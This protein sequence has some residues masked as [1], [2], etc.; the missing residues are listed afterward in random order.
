MKEFLIFFRQ[1]SV[2]LHH[3]LFEYK[4]IYIDLWS[5]NH[6]LS[7]MI[8]L[9]SLTAL[10]WKNRWR[11]LFFFLSAFE[12]VEATL[13]IALLKL[14]IPE[15]IPDVFMDVFLGMLGGYLIYLL[16]EKIPGILLYQSRIVMLISA[17]TISFLWTGFYGYQ[18][19][20][21]AMNSPGINVISFL[22][23]ALGGLAILLLHRAFK[24]TIRNRFIALTAFYLTYLSGLFFGKWISYYL[25]NIK[26]ISREASGFLFGFLPYNN[27]LLLFYLMSPVF[28][29]LLNR[30]LF[31]IF[32][33]QTIKSQYASQ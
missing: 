3:N 15:K 16:F 27:A 12:L 19:N 25:L 8:V 11:W 24:K 17:L 33:Q 5:I 21:N 2:W 4:L 6:F 23:W 1:H 22:S 13:F 28:F 20:I 10:G 26:E 31:H 32:N 14:F 30:G 9:A 29:I 7:G 18:Y